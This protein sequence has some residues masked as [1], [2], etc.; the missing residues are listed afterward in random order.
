MA[1][2]AIHFIVKEV[3]RQASDRL[4]QQG[5]DFESAAA[6]IERASAHWLRHTSG[7]HLSEKADLKEGRDKLGHAN[8]STTS[9]YLHFEDD[10]RHD[11]TAAH[12]RVNW[13][14]P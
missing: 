12:H 2:S 7:S 8:I 6:H 13:R 14:T 11:A 4:L 3:V 9:I 5:P 10:A 1:R